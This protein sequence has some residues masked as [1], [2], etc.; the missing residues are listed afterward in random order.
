MGEILGRPAA[1]RD[2]KLSAPLPDAGV[3]LAR[4]DG[5]HVRLDLRA[6]SA[7]EG[8]L[9]TGRLGARMQLECARCLKAFESPATVDVCELFATPGHELPPEEDTYEVSGSE[10]DLEPMVRDSLV[11]ALPIHP[12]CREDC[13]GI[14]ATCGSDLN[15]TTCDCSE[16]ESD[17]RWAALD[18][19]RARLQA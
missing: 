2:I 5:N 14:C 17:P 6:E 4:V 3:S 11:L 15:E 13:A 18:E 9:V 12:L 1:Y 16:D 7:V 8:I 10:I 19:I